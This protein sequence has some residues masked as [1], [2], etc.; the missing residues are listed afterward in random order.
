LSPKASQCAEVE[1]HGPVIQSSAI[2]GL[3]VRSL[4]NVRLLVE[5]L[6]C[7]AYGET[8]E[9]SAQSAQRGYP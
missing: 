8:R 5:T 7:G 1:A 2:L 4:S 9:M 3:V 6:V